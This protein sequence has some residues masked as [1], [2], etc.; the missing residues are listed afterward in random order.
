MPKFGAR[1][2]AIFAVMLTLIVITSATSSSLAKTV[3]KPKRWCY[4]KGDS[5]VTS[6]T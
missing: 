4:G 3:L 5:H 2:S 1:L 6:H